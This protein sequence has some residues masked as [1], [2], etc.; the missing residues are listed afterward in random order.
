MGNNFSRPMILS[1]W[2]EVSV[3]AVDAK[4]TSEGGLDSPEAL[5]EFWTKFGP[6]EQ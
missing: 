3:Q 2:V 5:L 4:M 1:I 6:R